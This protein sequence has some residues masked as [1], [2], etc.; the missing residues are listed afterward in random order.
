M[1]P[2]SVLPGCLLPSRAST[3]PKGVA[4]RAISANSSA[5]VHTPAIWEISL[6]DGAPCCRMADSMQHQME[7]RAGRFSDRTSAL[8]PR[9]LFAG[10]GSFPRSKAFQVFARDIQ[11]RRA[12]QKLREETRLG[13]YSRQPRSRAAREIL[14]RTP[15][16]VSF[17]QTPRLAILLA[18]RSSIYWSAR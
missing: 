9:L 11:A 18:L 12:M 8:P 10:C 2:D 5:N 6:H 15:K 1:L 7:I 17:Q 4:K 3:V 14:P 16:T 13:S